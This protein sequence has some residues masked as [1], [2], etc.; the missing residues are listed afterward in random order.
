MDT[1][2]FEEYFI[3]DYVTDWTLRPN[4]TEIAQENF[5]FISKY[6][7]VITVEE[8]GDNIIISG[9]N[10][11]HFAKDVKSSG[12]PPVSYSICLLSSLAERSSYRSS[13]LSNLGTCS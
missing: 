12:R 10:S 11:H 5:T 3:D 1:L 4:T 2:G 8:K 6:L 7:N 13:L 9:I